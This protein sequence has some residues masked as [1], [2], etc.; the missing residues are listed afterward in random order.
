MTFGA[1]A[2]LWWLALAPLV[3]LLYMLRARREPRLV[4]AVL[5]WERATRD[6]VAR[7][8]MRRLERN[9][10]L[11]LQILIIVLVV[12]ALARPSVALRG[13][14][15]DAV[16]LV[17]DTS[18]SMQATDVA[19]S[20]LDAA[21]QTAEA[22]LA[23]LGPRQPAAVVTA[24]L[25]PRVVA[26]FGTDRAVL[27]A[28]LRSIRATDAASAIDEAAALAGSLRAGGRP[29]AVHVFGDRAPS[30]PSVTWH[31]VGGRPANAG[32]T[33]AQ[34]RQD[35]R[36]RTQLMVRVEAFGGTATRTLT[37]AI[38]GREL[39]AREVT[40]APG[41]PNITL[42]DLAQSTGL[43]EVRL[44]GADA[45]AADDR[46]LVAVG[47]EAR[48][49]I[50]VVGEP[51]PVTEALFRAVPAA[52]VS[53]QAEPAPARWGRASLVVLDRVAPLELPPGAYLLI[54]TMG[55]NL[56]VQI[57]GTA[58]QQ[59]VRTV[60]GTHPVMR[61]A[62]LRGARVAETLAIR[63]AAGSVL[64]EGDV[65][66]VWAYEGRGLRLVLL[67]FDLLASDLPVH[68]AFPVLIANAVDWLAGSPHAR[69][70]EAP[71]VPAGRASRATLTQPHGEAQSLEARGGVFVLPPLERVGLYRLRA[72][73]WERRWV[74]PTADPRESSL[75]VDA[76]G[77][78]AP[79]R[80]V[81]SQLA[82]VR[83]APW[84]LG[85]AVVLVAGEWWLWVRTVPR[86][87]RARGGP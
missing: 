59:T 65:P 74:V 84:L 37:V 86:R 1:P 51:S 48:P 58:A 62:D 78:A 40:V 31:A 56:P 9:L 21:R 50:V 81:M 82:Q 5:L 25:H 75:A 73:D 46:A 44:R 41:R 43:A 12:L 47:Q 27:V 7:L 13:L 77:A 3:V 24:G 2:A 35:A 33:A 38:A 80:P 52:E 69:L 26:E 63:S 72:D 34:A 22:L 49:V 28:A 54:G 17:V 79:A 29:G 66:L 23:R 18:A 64:A 42:L 4:P 32:I 71:V 14:A 67:P 76:P 19:P 20:R 8:P 11:L 10:L 60:S 85:L 61:L 30:D 53:R 68:P 36:G 57:E 55:T 6:L 83:L 87:P 70:G 16:V 45:L 15:G 39:A